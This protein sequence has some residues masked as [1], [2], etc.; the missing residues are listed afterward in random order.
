MKKVVVCGAFDPLHLG[1]VRLLK[2]AGKRGKLHVVVARDG[3]I[4][5]L[6]KRK[7]FYTEKERIEFLRELKCVD[8]AVLGG[9]CD[10]LAVLRRIKPDV[11]VLGY[12]QK[13]DLAAI[14]KALPNAAIVREKKYSRHKS[15][16]K[17]K[18]I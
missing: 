7:P 1:H 8:N 2:S 9:T 10:L 4:K 17:R 6:K 12:D 16:N 11:I 5:R 15:S 18:V 14:S 13:A 3:N